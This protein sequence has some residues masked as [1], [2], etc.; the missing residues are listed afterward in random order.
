LVQYPIL[1]YL[2]TDTFKFYDTGTLRVLTQY[3][4]FTNLCVETAG[5]LIPKNRIYYKDTYNSD[6]CNCSAFSGD[7]VNFS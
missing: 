2:D 3:R 7:V 6:F 4:Y 1:I 5:Y